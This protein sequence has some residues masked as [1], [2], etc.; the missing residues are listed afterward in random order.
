MKSYY[1]KDFSIK[2]ATGFVTLRTLRIKTNIG[3]K[4]H[5]KASIF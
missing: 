1:L 4:Y 5:D 2:D 3:Q